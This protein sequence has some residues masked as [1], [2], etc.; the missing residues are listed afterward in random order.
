MATNQGT[1]NTQ[2][3]KEL[4]K[5]SIKLED[6][7]FENYKFSPFLMTL[8]AKG[9][10]TT[11]TQQKF[12]WL[13]TQ[14]TSKLFKLENVDNSATTVNVKDTANKNIV[15][16][17]IIKGI[18]TGEV[19]KVTA[20]TDRALTVVRGYSGTTKTAVTGDTD[21]GFMCI[22]EAI[23]EGS[24]TPKATY[25]TKGRNFNYSQIFRRSVK[26]TRNKMKQLEYGI[27]GDKRKEERNKVL[28]L[29]QNDIEMAL[30]Y[31]TPYEDLTGADPLY[32][33]GGLMH[34]IK[35]NILEIASAS[36]FK[37]GT[38]E[39]FMG[40]LADA[41]A[42]GDKVMLVGSKFNAYLNDNAIKTFAGG[43]GAILKE[44]GVTTDMITT[45]YGELNIMYNQT[46]SQVYPN[47][48]IIV[49]MDTVK[50]HQIERTVMNLDEQ[51][52]GYDGVVDNIL[53]DCGLEV[54][55]EA[56]NGIIRL[57]F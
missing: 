25:L 8:L 24:S 35:T 41:G 22:S 27:E 9:R 39:A 14:V 16:G 10:T 7:I 29:H 53:T 20:V 36:D 45:P 44:Y 17:M 18:T 21:N 33:T 42:A 52:P 2:V 19:M 40:K 37:V 30:L 54:N 55:N 47:T 32:Q 26:I 50:L 6:K 34:Y 48:A 1:W 56:C 11:E 49:D 43:A 28:K 38:I 57:N 5:L 31:G 23:P 13:E 12:E 51:E 15:E 4:K 46:L 3:E